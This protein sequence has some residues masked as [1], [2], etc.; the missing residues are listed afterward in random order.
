MIARVYT[1]LNCPVCSVF[2]ASRQKI[3]G[4]TI[5][6]L[7]PLPICLQASAHEHGPTALLFPV[8]PGSN[9]QITNRILCEWFSI[10]A[11]PVY[12]LVHMFRFRDTLNTYRL[13]KYCTKYHLYF[14]PRSQLLP[15]FECNDFWNFHKS[16]SWPRGKYNMVTISK[17]CPVVVTTNI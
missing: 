6:H 7:F 11:H 9:V 3:I 13:E 15:L 2:H 4:R 5:Q 1:G 8:L 17:Y 16:A 14:L 10:L 12:I